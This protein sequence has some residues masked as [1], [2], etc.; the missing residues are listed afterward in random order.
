MFFTLKH[1]YFCGGQLLNKGSQRKLQ[2]K[3]HC[4]QWVNGCCRHWG[5]RMSDF[6]MKQL[7]DLGSW[8]DASAELWRHWWGKECRGVKP[9]SSGERTY[10]RCSF[11]VCAK[12]LSASKC[13]SK[14]TAFH[15]KYR[16]SHARWPTLWAVLLPPRNRQ[17]WADCFSEHQSLPRDNLVICLFDIP[18]RRGCGAGWSSVSWPRQMSL[19]T[20]FNPGRFQFGWSFCGGSEQCV[21]HSRS[22]PEIFLLLAVREEIWLDELNRFDGIDEKLVVDVVRV[23]RVESLVSLEQW[24]ESWARQPA[25]R[26]WK[27]GERGLVE[28]RIDDANLTWEVW[29]AREGES[30]LSVLLGDV[31]QAIISVFDNCW[32]IQRRRKQLKL[33]NVRK[34]LERMWSTVRELAVETYWMFVVERLFAGNSFLR[35]VSSTELWMTSSVDKEWRMVLRFSISMSSICWRLRKAFKINPQGKIRNDR[36]IV[37]WTFL[38]KKNQYIKNIEL[39]VAPRLVV[40]R[41]TC[42]KIFQNNWLFWVWL[43]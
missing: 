43:V 14:P 10:R 9:G 29:K 17:Y 41:S 22:P 18:C 7:F 36:K 33:C 28:A 20:T 42:F 21:H 15:R 30:L 12:I 19:S 38:D 34:H 26:H 1:S 32:E 11:N 6:V 8:D 31:G 40:P 5:S 25:R 2:P 27:Q 24:P 16:H 23:F 4:F 13:Q 37:F 3:Q 35:S 39:L